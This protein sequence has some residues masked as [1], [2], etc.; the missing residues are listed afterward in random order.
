MLLD[1]YIG[2]SNKRLEALVKKEF[3]RRRKRVFSGNAL[4]GLEIGTRSV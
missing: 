2:F 3:L 4:A 1:E